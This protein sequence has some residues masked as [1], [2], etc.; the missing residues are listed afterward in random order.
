MVELGSIERCLETRM[1]NTFCISKGQDAPHFYP[2]FA[3]D[4]PFL[5]R[6][7]QRVPKLAERSKSKG[8][9]GSPKTTHRT[10]DTPYRKGWNRL[11]GD[12]RTCELPAPDRPF[13]IALQGRQR[14]A[15]FGNSITRD[16]P[17]AV[18]HS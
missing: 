2:R 6:H 17:V 1:D 16:R 10:F 5:A 12:V 9:V 15:N 14:A 18:V 7:F 4:T 8:R 3:F 11:A 13:R